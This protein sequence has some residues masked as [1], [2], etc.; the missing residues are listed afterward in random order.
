L[1]LGAVRNRRSL[2]HVGNLA[3]LIVSAASSPAAAGRTFLAADGEDLSTPQLVSEIA[4]AL[5]VRARLISV[6]VALLRLGGAISGM[7]AEI[8]RLVDSLVVDAS[9]TRQRLGW[10]PP[11]SVG[12]GIAETVRWYR[13]AMPAR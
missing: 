10:R 1:P 3:D 7:G 2:I 8:G 11:F 4:A 13:S 6:P 9:E 5:G 12:E